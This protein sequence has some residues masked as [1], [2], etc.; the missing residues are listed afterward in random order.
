MKNPDERVISVRPKIVKALPGVPDS[1]LHV[2][3]HFDSQ[4]APPHLEH[5]FFNFLKALQQLAGF[6]RNEQSLNELSCR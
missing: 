6:S 4:L 1:T 3:K 5:L 2:H